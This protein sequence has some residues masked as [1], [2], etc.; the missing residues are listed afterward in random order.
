VGAKFKSCDSQIFKY[1]TFLCNWEEEHNRKI[2]AA[3]LSMKYQC[4][5][6]NLCLLFFFF[7]FFGGGGGGGGQISHILM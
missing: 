2:E 7:L 3:N 6:T 4:M 5:G 1:L